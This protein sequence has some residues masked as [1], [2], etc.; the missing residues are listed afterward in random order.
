MRFIYHDGGRAAA[1]YKGFTG[2]CAARA[3]A[4][5][6]GLSYQD[7]YDRINAVASKERRGRRKRG[8]SNARTGVYGPAIRQVMTGLGWTFTPTMT[9][10]SGCRVHLRDGELPM[11][12]LVVNISKHYVAVIDGVMYDTHDPSRGGTRCVY[13]YFSKPK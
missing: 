4:I 13:G 10:G 5:A 7:I 3:I 1:G 6:T 12:R 8:I 11:G 2:D 9:I